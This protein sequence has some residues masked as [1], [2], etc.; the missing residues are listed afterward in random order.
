MI[1]IHAYSWKIYMQSMW[2]LM[3]HSV[4]GFVGN[5]T[6]VQ[7]RDLVLKPWKTSTNLGVI[8]SSCHPFLLYVLQL[9]MVSP[10]SYQD[11]DNLRFEIS[12][13]QSLRNLTLSTL[14]FLEPCL[15]DFFPP[16]HFL[17]GEL[18]NGSS[19]GQVWE[20]L[21]FRYSKAIHHSLHVDFNQ[22]YVIR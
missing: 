11:I 20:F 18:G 12:P 8:S 15:H 21:P 19:K 17:C 9:W 16:N 22:H 6:V 3:V 2:K 13:K 14:W 5:Y 1:F 7:K 4:W 10:W